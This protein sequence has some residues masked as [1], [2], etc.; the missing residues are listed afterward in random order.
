MSSWDAKAKARSKRRLEY[1]REYQARRLRRL[2]ISTDR[3]RPIMPTDS[4]GITGEKLALKL[5]KNSIWKGERI[6]LIWLNKKI[7]VKTSKPHL[8]KGNYPRWK[9]ILTR[10]K[11][12]VDFF[13]LFG[14]DE[15]KKL[16]AVYFIPDKEIENT[17]IS[18]LIGRPSKYNKYLISLS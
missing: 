2:G 7:D 5:L 8:M 11:G 9:F 4:T 3:D 1:F 16:Q 17:N 10:Q 15:Q 14:L 6:D 13:I 12:L 18:I